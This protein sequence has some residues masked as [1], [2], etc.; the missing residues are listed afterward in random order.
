[1]SVIAVILLMFSGANVYI[2][3][4]YLIQRRFGLFWGH[5]F[6]AAVILIEAL[7]FPIRLHG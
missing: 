7:K 4:D 1:M 2:G 5:T 6:L 3:L